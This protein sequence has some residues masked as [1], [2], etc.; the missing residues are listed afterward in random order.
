M[1]QLTPCYN[2]PRSPLLPKR[3][4]PSGSSPINIPANQLGL[5][6]QSISQEMFQQD[7]HGLLLSNME[8]PPSC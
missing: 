3:K 4:N 8:G 7:I 2:L 6:V 1:L 5:F